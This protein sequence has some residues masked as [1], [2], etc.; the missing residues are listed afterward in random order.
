MRTFHQITE[1]A[2][3]IHSLYRLGVLSALLA[4]TA[5]SSG[6]LS[7]TTVEQAPQWV[8]GVY[9]PS[10]QFDKLCVSPKTGIN[11]FTEQPYGHSPG[12]AM[13]EKMWIRSMS[14]DVYLW[15][16]QLPDPNPAT[17]STI[18]KYFDLLKTDFDRFH[19]TAPVE[20][21]FNSSQSGVVFSYG[22]RWHST[23]NGLPR[24]ADVQSISGL[25]DQIRRGDHLVAVDGIAL[26]KE[27]HSISEAEIINA[28]IS[29]S[30]S[31]PTHTLTFRDGNTG[32]SKTLR[33]TARAL[34]HNPVPR[35]R[36][37]DHNQATFGYLQFD[38]HNAIAQDKLIDAMTEFSESGID[39]LILDLRYNQ[40]GAVYIASQLSYMIAGAGSTDGMPFLFPRYNDKLDQVDPF[41][42][43]IRGFPFLTT[44]VDSATDM[45]LPTLNLDRVYVITSGY[46]CSASESII[47]GLKGVGVDVIQMGSPT[48][49]KPYVFQPMENCGTL[50]FTI[51]FSSEN[52]LGFGDY[53]N[54]FFPTSDLSMV[55]ESHLPGC[56]GSDDVNYPLGSIEEPLLASAL[57]WHENGTCPTA[58]ASAIVAKQKWSGGSIFWNA[59]PASD[60]WKSNAIILPQE[61]YLD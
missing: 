9:E 15:Y 26:D 61:L 28:G 13:H 16:D 49:G 60:P 48:C 59:P 5:C 52:A 35:H 22:I 20:T 1:P 38:D 2:R 30:A 19:F 56:T 25:D 58:S 12:T 14:N 29:P 23:A 24:V 10:S 34:E 4:L 7:S 50:Y 53:A 17:V 55:N 32:E 47:N 44:R 40:G 3:L 57:N 41:G 11:P 21:F 39:E 51:M 31:N 43:P 6:Q 54:G 27:N 36:M 18:T 33:L 45:P 8:P 42:N 37:F 46:T